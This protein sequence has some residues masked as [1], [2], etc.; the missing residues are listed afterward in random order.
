MFIEVHEGTRMSF[1][2]LQKAVTGNV[3]YEGL[4]QLYLQYNSYTKRSFASAI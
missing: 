1:H 3:G 4:T 2:I